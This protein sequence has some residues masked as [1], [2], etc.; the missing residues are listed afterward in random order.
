MGPN[1][2]DNFVLAKL[3]QEGLSPRRRRIATR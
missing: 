2:I 3:E 1:P